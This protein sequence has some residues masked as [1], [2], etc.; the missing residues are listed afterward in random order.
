MSGATIFG[1]E[2]VVSKEIEQQLG[3]L[4]WEIEKKR[5]K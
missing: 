2:V 1:G 5:K 4:N 3:Q